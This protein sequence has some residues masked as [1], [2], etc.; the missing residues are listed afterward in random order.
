M[1]DTSSISCVECSKPSQKMIGAGLG[2]IY[3]G[4]GFYTT[5]YNRSQD[6]KE[7]TK[8]EKGE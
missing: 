6:Y 2:V 1:E 8:K 7:A 4:S 3:K 5:D